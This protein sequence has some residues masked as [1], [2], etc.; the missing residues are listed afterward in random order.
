M[1]FLILAQI[2]L[3][4]IAAGII[5]V[6]PDL[7]YRLLRW[8]YNVFGLDFERLVTARSRVLV[9]MRIAGIIGLIMTIVMGI[10]F[11]RFGARLL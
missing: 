11:W 5:V 2:G 10:M 9:G 4:A 8:S 3:F 7:Y 1:K 6:A